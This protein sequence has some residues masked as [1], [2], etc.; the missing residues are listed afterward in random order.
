MDKLRDAVMAKKD[1]EMV[2]P[3]AEAS[4]DDKLR[5]KLL[6]DSVKRKSS[7][8]LASKGKRAKLNKK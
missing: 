2:E 8:A 7:S 5:L 4:A 3:Q 6:V 1:L